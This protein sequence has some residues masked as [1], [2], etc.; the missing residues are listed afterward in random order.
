MPWLRDGWRDTLRPKPSAL[1]CYCHSACPQHLST[2]GGGAGAGGPQAIVRSPHLFPVPSPQVLEL[3][4]LLLA[5]YLQLPLM[6]P[7]QALQLSCQVPQEF[8]PLLPL[9]QRG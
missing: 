6:G 3:P 1:S 7:A 2:L 9:L 4:V 5:H 8:S